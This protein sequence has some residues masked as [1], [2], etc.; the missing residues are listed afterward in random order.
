LKEKSERIEGGRFWQRGKRAGGY[1]RNNHLLPPSPTIKNAGDR[2][3]GRWRGEGRRRPRPWGRPRSGAKR[4]GGRGQLISLLTF[5]GDG[6]WREID[7]GGRSATRNGTSGT[8]G[9]DGE[10][11]EEGELVVEVRDEVGSR[12]DPFIGAERR[13][14]RRYSSSRS[15]DGRQWGWGGEI[16]W[17]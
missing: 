14:G 4:R 8:G 11:R 1:G 3:A 12:S 13:F 15:F 6:L 9:G 5:V 16:S 10:L 2:M 7:G 17:H